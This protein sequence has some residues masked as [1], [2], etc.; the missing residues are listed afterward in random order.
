MFKLKKKQK[1]VLTLFI[2]ELNIYVQVNQEEC[3][4]S[5]VRYQDSALKSITVRHLIEQETIA[6]LNWFFV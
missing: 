2:H 1:I 3:W 4:L 5:K 6:L